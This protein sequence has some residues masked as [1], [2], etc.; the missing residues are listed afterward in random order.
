MLDLPCFDPA[1][2]ADLAGVQISI[3]P[4]LANIV[5]NRR[6]IKDKVINM[7]FVPT[8]ITVTPPGGTAVEV[9]P[10]NIPFQLHTDCPGAC[11][12]DTVIET[13]FVLEGTFAQ[14]GISVVVGTGKTELGFVAKAI[15]RTTL[16][17]VRPVL[18]DKH[19]DVCDVNFDRCDNNGTPPTFTLPSTPNGNGA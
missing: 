1:S 9:G 11:P 18:V 19:G 3:V 14:P 2:I 17:V 8:T 13:P 10:F 16:T 12:E 7:G 4:D 15:F 6:V 5:I